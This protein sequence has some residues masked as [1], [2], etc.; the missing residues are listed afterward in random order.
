MK[1]V[2]F[3]GGLG[4]RMRDGSGSIPKPMVTI[5]N[6][7]ILWHIMKYYAHFG[8]KDFILCLGYR[9]EAIKDFFLNYNE[10]L[11]NDFV[12]SDGGKRVELLRSD[13]DDWRITFVDTG[14]HSSIGAAALRGPR[15]PRRRRDASSPPT[16]TASPTRRCPTSMTSHDVAQERR[17]L[18]LRAADELLVPHGRGE[19]QRARRR[20][21][22]HHRRRTS[23]STAAS[24]SSTAGSS[25]IIEDGEDLV[26]RAVQPPD[27]GEAGSRLPLRRLLGA[28]GHAE[29]QAQPG[30]APRE[31]SPAVA[32]LG[33][34]RASRHVSRMLSAEAST[35]L[36]GRPRRF[37]RSA[38]TPTTSRS[39]AAARCSGWSRDVPGARGALGR[40][41]RQ[42]RSARP[43]PG[44]A[45]TP[46]STGVAKQRIVTETFRDGFFPYDGRRDQG[47]LRAAQGRGLAGP[48][49]HPPARR[50]APGSP[51][52]R[53]ADLEHVPRTT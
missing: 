16:A 41:E 48:D 53:R 27:R 6:R 30:S 23:G 37:S 26:E 25:T 36:P 46:S 9:A 39:A 34:E 50:P 49:P 5:G 47:V 33:A 2:L 17:H 19:A 15:V 38:R 4:L 13:I 14:L 20:H 35:S 3:C 51:S 21:P 18:P 24:S 43:R 40:P 1:V 7:P 28:D 42:R 31:R 22:G 44:P 10:A 29:G 12:L 52:R 8:H 45:P 11:S 32:A